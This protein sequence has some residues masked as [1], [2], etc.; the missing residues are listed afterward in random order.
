MFQHHSRGDIT[1]SCIKTTIH[2]SILYPSKVNLGVGGPTCC[3]G[4][5]Q[6]V[7]CVIYVQ[8]YYY[9]MNKVTYY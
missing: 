7:L 6:V 8:N 5:M 2:C 1:K 4:D 9:T 3:Y